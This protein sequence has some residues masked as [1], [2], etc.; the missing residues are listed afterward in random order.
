MGRVRSSSTSQ[1]PGPLDEDADTT[2]EIA[3]LLRETRLWRIANHAQWVAWGIVQA[4]VAGVGK[5]E[6][7]AEINASGR[8]GS[9]EVVLHGHGRL[10]PTE[11]T[12]PLDEEAKANVQ[13]LKDK[14]PEGHSLEQSTGEAA[15]DSED[16]AETEEEFDYLGYARERAMFFWGDCLQLG[17]VSEEI[18]EQWG[19][20]EQVKVV[21]Y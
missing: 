15:A 2:A 1:T 9:E 14:R 8:D 16:D 19:I 3:G 17:L 5:A 10:D 6:H 13:D 4:K 11:G 18:L 21:P 20:A 12:D 7:G